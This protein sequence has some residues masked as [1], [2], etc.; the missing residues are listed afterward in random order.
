MHPRLQCSSPQHGFIEE[1]GSDEGDVDEGV[2]RDV[3]GEDESGD[4][5]ADFE[6]EGAGR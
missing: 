3:D 1:G 5:Y 2:A 6:G 4:E